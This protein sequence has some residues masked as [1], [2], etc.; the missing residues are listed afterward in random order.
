[1]DK[2]LSSQFDSELAAVSTRVMEMGGLVESQIRTAVYALAQFSAEAAADLK[3]R[4]QLEM[5]GEP[6]FWAR[7]EEGTIRIGRGEIENP[8]LVVRGSASAI[9]GFV[10]AGAPLSAIDVEGDLE[11]AARLPGFFPMPEKAQRSA[12]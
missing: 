2:H 11:L 9:A 5:N 7:D 6:F 10:Y 1:M 3:A 4:I 8:D 12:A